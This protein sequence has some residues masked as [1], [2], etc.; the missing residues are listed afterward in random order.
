MGMTDKQF[1]AYVLGQ[2]RRLE[3]AKSDLAKDGAKSEVLDLM[4]KDLQEQ[5]KRP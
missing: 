4:I 5:L 3:Q 2:L 1:D